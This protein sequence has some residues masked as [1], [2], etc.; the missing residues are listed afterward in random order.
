[1]VLF[2]DSHAAQFFPALRRIGAREGWRLVS[3]TKSACTPADVEL[4]SQRLGR[5][6]EECAEWRERALERIGEER[7]D[8]TIVSGASLYSVAEDG[9]RL[10]GRNSKALE[11]GLVRTL[12]RLRA[13][14]RKVVVIADIPY[15]PFDVPA[16]VSEHLD[17]LDECAFDIAERRNAK[18]FDRRAAKAVKGVRLVEVTDAIC[19]RGL[20]RAVIGDALTY[21]DA[22]HLSA[23]FVRT[24][25]PLLEARL[26]DLD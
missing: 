25:A 9:E 17:A 23:T 3:L 14:S 2:G 16:C 10:E 15:P 26:P 11:A 4:W 1:M 22:T 13:A 21:R 19:P 8:M 18:P 12:E 24:L 7:P 20:C 6:Y 5:L